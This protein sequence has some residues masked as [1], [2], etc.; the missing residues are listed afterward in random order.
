MSKLENKNKQNRQN[1]NFFPAV[2]GKSNSISWKFKFEDDILLWS[3]QIRGVFST[4]QSAFIRPPCS[5]VPVATAPFI[6]ENVLS[7]KGD[8]PAWR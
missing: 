6:I 3:V 5:Q 7:K 2:S 1:E 8:P 4:F